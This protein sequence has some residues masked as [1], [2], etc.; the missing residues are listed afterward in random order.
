M[1]S[2]QAAQAAFDPLRTVYCY[3]VQALPDAGVLPRILQSFAKLGVV[4]RRCH[5]AL[6]GAAEQRLVVDVQVQGLE[7]VMAEHIADQLRA[8]VCVDS[9]LTARLQA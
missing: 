2:S 7:E 9:V 4:P 1:S 3:S 6:E 5:A 8:S